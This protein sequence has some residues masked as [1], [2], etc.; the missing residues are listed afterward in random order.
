MDIN[1]IKKLSVFKKVYKVHNKIFENNK[2]KDYILSKY[3]YE[4]RGAFIGSIARLYIF[5]NDSEFEEC[6]NMANKNKSRCPSLDKYISRYGFEEGEKRHQEYRNKLSLAQKGIN[7]TERLPNNPEYW[8]KH[9]YSP[10]EAKKKS[11]EVRSQYVSKMHK[12]RKINNPLLY[13]EINKLCVEYWEKRFPEDF[14]IRYKNHMTNDFNLSKNKLK[15]ELG[16]DGYKEFILK[17]GKACRAGIIKSGFSS[18]SK[19]SIRHFIPIYRYLRKKYRLDKT[20]I[21]WGIGKQKEYFLLH[22]KNLPWFYDFVIPKYKI[23]IEFNGEFYH[24]RTPND[25]NYKAHCFKHG[26]RCEDK[27]ILDQKKKNLAISKGF[28]I[29]EI[30]DSETKQEN[31]K[32]MKVFVDEQ[33]KQKTKKI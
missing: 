5:S 3:D 13:R 31:F 29:L 6:L 26:V 25:P 12:N 28:D 27:Y 30:W 22:T 11:S 2:H 18:T 32:L 23:I 15:E 17:R 20:D 19:I 21:Y 10:E 14:E 16:E 24:P 33:I 1:R 7:K 4:Y 9:N 8:L